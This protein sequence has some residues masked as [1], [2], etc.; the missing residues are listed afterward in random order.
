MVLVA[1]GIVIPEIIL[2]L[3]GLLILISV[4]IYAIR[5]LGFDL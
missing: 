3:I 4:V 2:T 1:I 5:A